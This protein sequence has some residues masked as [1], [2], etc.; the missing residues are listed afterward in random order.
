MTHQERRVARIAKANEMAALYRQG[1]TLKE[2]G[3]RYG[4]TR[5]R[6][7]QLLK[8]IG[9]DGKQGGAA[10]VA[11]A[12]REAYQAHLDAKSLRLRG[13]THAEFRALPRKVLSAYRNQRRNARTRGIEWKFNLASW[14][15][16]WELS[17]KWFQ[18]GRG[19]GYVMARK[20]DAGPYSPDNVYI[21][22]S[23]Q[24]ASDQY[25]W[26]P[27]HKRIRK[28]TGR[29]AGKLI[30]AFGE[31]HTVSEWSRIKGL[32]LSTL[33]A[34]LKRGMSPEDALTRPIKPTITHLTR[35]QKQE[36]RA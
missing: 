32:G 8:S 5:E 27:A 13:M 19:Y 10:L 21:C 28:A 1:L 34:R 17:G 20:G 12:K 25:I 16:I 14:W 31:V 15:R 4:V 22:T 9:A 7:R 29:P 33:D 26:K 6:V 3:D 18:R 36:H 11:K 35:L 2:V 23:A 30:E 24:N